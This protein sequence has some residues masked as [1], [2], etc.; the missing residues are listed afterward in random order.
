MGSKYEFKVDSNPTFNK[1]EPDKSKDFI[2][3]KTYNAKISPRRNEASIKQQEKL[4]DPGD[5]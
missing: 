2:S 5:Y 1:Y 3:T 4:P